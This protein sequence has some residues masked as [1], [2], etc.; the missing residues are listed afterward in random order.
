MDNSS[1]GA[2]RIDIKKSALQNSP[3]FSCIMLEELQ[4]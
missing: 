1:F 3:V 4:I 2:V